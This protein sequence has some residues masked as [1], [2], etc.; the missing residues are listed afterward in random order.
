MPG[1]DYAAM[2]ERFTGKAL[3]PG[4][5]VDR[6]GRVLGE[7]KGIECYTVGQRRGLGL[8]FG[9]PMYVCAIRPEDHAVVLGPNDALFSREVSVSSFHWISGEVPSDPVRGTAKIRYRHREAPVTAY[10][11][12]DGG[13]L[14]VFDD[15]Q[16]AAAP[17]QSAVLYDGDT[18]LG[19]GVISA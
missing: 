10:P 2:I 18:V 14:L 4:L 1:G 12:P 6:A 8:A 13:V 16:R 9:E 3:T 17:G 11:S 15:P 5:F 19:G 7:H